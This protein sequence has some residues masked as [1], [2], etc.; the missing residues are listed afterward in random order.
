[1]SYLKYKYPYNFWAAP[2]EFFYDGPLINVGSDFCL[3]PSK[4][5]PG[6]IV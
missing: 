1:M 6:G 3:M 5:E 4:F 2:D